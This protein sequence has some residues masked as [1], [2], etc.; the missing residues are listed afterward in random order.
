M[1]MVETSNGL[2]QLEK[3]FADAKI[4]TTSPGFYED[5]QFV[6]RETR[7]PTYINNYARYVQWQSYTP[8]YLERAEEVVQVVVAEMLLAMQLDMNKLAYVE[9]PLVIS[10]ILEREGIWNY[11]A[12]GALNVTFPI[13]SGFE[14][15]T[16][17]TVDVKDRSKFAHGSTWVVVPPFQIVDLQIQTYGYPH[18]VSHLLPRMVLEKD[19]KPT[20]V[21]PAELL[22][23]AAVEEA[24]ESGIS[25]A[26][27]LD[28]LAPGYL[29]RFAPDFPALEFSR[30]VTQFRYVPTE[31][32]T[33][34]EMLEQ[35][36]AFV[37][38][39]RYAMQIYDEEIRPR[40]RKS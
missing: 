26:Q 19:A 37:S 27:E 4:D 5:F 11:V 31:I 17:W 15:F 18:P 38:K 35:M 34:D 28:N 33:T 6:R 10:R 14:P 39:G 3:E 22:S 12:R 23:P 40:L 29:D 7:D 21:D 20:T 1:L 8:A 30:D 25:L 9:S 32:V 13:D 16:I 36:Q 2:A 24:H